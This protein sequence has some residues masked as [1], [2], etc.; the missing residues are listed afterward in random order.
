MPRLKEPTALTKKVAN[1][2]C[3]LR[4][5]YGMNQEELARASHVSKGHLSNIE[6][7][8]V[9]ITI[10]TI[11]KLAAGFKLELFDLFA[12][13]ELNG[14]HKLVDRS[15]RP[16]SGNVRLIYKQWD[17]LPLSKKPAKPPK[18]PPIRASGKKRSKRV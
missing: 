12:F 5:E 15:R 11:E 8:L 14:R 13:P 3:K 10:Q 6:K 7:G 1:R 18:P 9:R 4:E 16:T 17:K 2:I